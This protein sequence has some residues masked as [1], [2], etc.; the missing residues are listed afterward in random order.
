MRCVRPF[1]SL[2]LTCTTNN[3][4]MRSMSSTAR[5][6]AGMKSTRLLSIAI[7]T[8]LGILKRCPDSS[9]SLALFDKV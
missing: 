9:I 6:I 2:P 5:S 8:Y 3:V 7:D 4:T 1:D